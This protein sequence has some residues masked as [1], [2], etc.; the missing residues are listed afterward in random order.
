MEVLRTDPIHPRIHPKKTRVVREA[1]CVPTNKSVMAVWRHQER[2]EKTFPP[3]W[4]KS[5]T[6]RGEGARGASRHVRIFLE[7]VYGF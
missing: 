3:E 2:K 6:Q 4:K 5:E 1:E 7:N